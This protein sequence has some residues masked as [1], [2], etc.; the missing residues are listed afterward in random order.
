MSIIARNAGRNTS[1]TPLI[2]SFAAAASAA[3]AMVRTMVNRRR[4]GQI[5]DMPDYL[6][7]DLGLKR[8]DVHD[9]LAQGW[10]SDPTYQLAIAAERRRRCLSEG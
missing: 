7:S 4:V 8:D 3:A 1:A 9:A 10:R 5:A 6:L 2:P